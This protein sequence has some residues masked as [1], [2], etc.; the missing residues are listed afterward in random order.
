MHKST[1]I[2]LTIFFMSAFSTYGQSNFKSFGGE[3]AE[4]IIVNGDVIMVNERDYM[5]I[6][7]KNRLYECISRIFLDGY[8]N[9]HRLNYSKDK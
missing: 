7:Y 6:K 5:I 9:C 4:N 8:I 2:W 3:E 1:I